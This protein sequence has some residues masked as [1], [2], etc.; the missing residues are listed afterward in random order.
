MSLKEPPSYQLPDPGPLART[1]DDLA[2]LVHRLELLLLTV[3]FKD[4]PQMIAVEHHPLVVQ[5]PP[6]PR[7]LLKVPQDPGPP[8]SDRCL[9][10]DPPSLWDDDHDVLSGLNLK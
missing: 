10:V 8:A 5:D 1:D 7:N 2:F 9:K 6:I 4:Y 3:L